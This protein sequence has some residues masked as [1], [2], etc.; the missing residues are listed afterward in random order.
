MAAVDRVHSMIVGLVWKYIFL[1]QR[2]GWI[3]LMFRNSKLLSSSI[4]LSLSLSLSLVLSP[5]N[6]KGA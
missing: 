6:Y 3:P 2:H 1:G 4:S 5:Q